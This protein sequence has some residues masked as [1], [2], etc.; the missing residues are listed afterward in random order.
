MIKTAILVLL[1]FLGTFSTLV[2]F[3]DRGLDITDEGLYLTASQHPDDNLI[4]PSSCYYLN[5]IVFKALHYNVILLRI[6]GLVLLTA[7]ALFL[8]FMTSKVLTTII[9]TMPRPELNILCMSFTGLGSLLYYSWGI[10]TPSYNS[11][12]ATFLNIFAGL[13]GAILVS[14]K[15][16]WVIAAGLCITLA[17]L[18]KI[19]V[20]IAL[21]I[22]LIYWLYQLK[23][24]KYWIDL[25]LTIAIGLG[26]YFILIQSFPAWQQMIERAT[27]ITIVDNHHPLQLLG[28]Y[29]YDFKFLFLNTL[30]YFSPLATLTCLLLYERSPKK[31]QPALLLAALICFAFFI[32]NFIHHGHFYDRKAHINFIVQFYVALLILLTVLLKALK[33]QAPLILI[34]FIV[35]LLALPFIG[36]LGTNNSIT[37]EILLYIT[38]WFA[39]FLVLCIMIPKHSKTPFYLFIVTFDHQFLHLHPDHWLTDNCPL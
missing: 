28:Y 36:C 32:A 3:S 22:I 14:R 16:L 18:V 34:T 10:F 19:F 2:F 1:L 23:L 4:W 20:G 9:I 37:T 35:F 31:F 29:L 12:T 6:S 7:S 17:F 15:R 25:S 26:T 13:L 8:G 5:G 30:S 11:L 27:S 24:L 38:S 21:L 33:P 39:C